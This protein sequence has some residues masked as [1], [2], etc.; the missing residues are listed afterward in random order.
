[1]LGLASTEAARGK[2]VLLDAA[3]TAKA[4]AAS[5]VCV[6]AS[7]TPLSGAQCSLLIGDVI[8]GV[9]D[10]NESRFSFNGVIAD[11]QLVWLAHDAPSPEPAP[12]EEQVDPA[13]PAHVHAHVGWCPGVATD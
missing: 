5:L 9:T 2:H 1:M 3:A 8:V 12:A 11:G 13:P 6:Q 7:V 10:L 4:G